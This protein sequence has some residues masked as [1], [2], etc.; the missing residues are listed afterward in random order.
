MINGPHL[1]LYESLAHPGGNVTGT[2]SW[3]ALAAAKRVAL[4]KEIVP[5]LARVT[6]LCNPD[7]PCTPMH[8]DAVLPALQTLGLES[9]IV[10][11]PAISDVD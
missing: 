5:Q 6:L 10:K 1:G 9:Q 8:L 4:L 2:D 7:S 3:S 11:V